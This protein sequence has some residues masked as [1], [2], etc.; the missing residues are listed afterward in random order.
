MS[1]DN[2]SSPSGDED[3]DT[4]K[5]ELKLVT[6]HD[7]DSI[8][9]ENEA[10]SVTTEQ[11]LYD[12]PDF[13]DRP[14]ASRLTEPTIG[15]LSQPFQELQHPIVSKE[16][17]YPY[18]YR[19]VRW[20][21]LPPDVR[22][23]LEYHKDRLHHYH[24]AF[25]SDHNN[26]VKTTFLE[27]AVSDQDEALLYA[28]VAFA[29]YH[30]TFAREDSG[31]CNF[32]AY[33]NQS[34]SLLQKSLKKPNTTTI[35]TILQLATIEV[36]LGLSEAMWRV[37]LNE[38]Q[39]FLGDW[40]NLMGHQKACYQLITSLFTP[41]TIME[42]E[43]Q[44]QIIRWYMRF[45]LFAGTLSG[46][47]L[48]LS[49]EWF[50]AC[51]EYHSRTARDRPH[52]IE[53]KIEEYIA[54]IRLLG[55]E[56]TTLLVMKSSV[57]RSHKQFEDESKRLLQRFKVVEY[58]LASACNNVPDSING[59]SGVSPWS[60]VT[61]F[62][63]VS[64]LEA[65]RALFLGETFAMNF[66]LLDFWTAELTMGQHTSKQHSAESEAIALRMC[67]VIDA[68]ESSD[69][70][71]KGAL[72][73]CQSPVGIAGLFLPRDQECIDWSC[74]KFSALEQLGSVFRISFTS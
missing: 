57:G 17:I 70:A 56:L 59:L 66:V 74:K 26:F 49:L 65:P 71:P 29:S 51:R 44:R 36:S 48:S 61:T 28:V 35:L 47:G 23:L 43:M 4:K 73:A 46:G 69:E 50:E 54:T 58:Q 15:T 8:H 31:I 68:I 12:E 52:D 14:D 10:Q 42:D 11:S 63:S 27:T 6:S 20:L 1:V 72:L 30:R 38:I 55:A 5:Q 41:Q 7:G 60:A 21:T 33:Y 45:D 9:D 19:S 13:I 22:L 40:V 64:G 18:G 25:R 32:L 37:E 34:I 53:A 24:Y 67:S 2:E 3:D 62:D 16:G 39:E